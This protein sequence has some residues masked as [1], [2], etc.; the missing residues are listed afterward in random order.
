VNGNPL[1]P[2]AW[3]VAFSSVWLVATES[4]ARTAVTAGDHLNVSP[5]WLDDR[6]L[7]FVS[8][9]DGRREVYVVEIGATGPAGAA[10]KVPGGTDAHSISV[11]ADGR[12]LAV[13]KFIAR[14]NVWSFPVTDGRP[15]TARE[16]RPVTSGT[17]VVETHALSPDGQSVVY[18]SDFHADASLYLLRINGGVPIPLVT[19]P[20]PVFFPAWSPDGREIAF[21]GGPDNGLWVVPAEGGAATRLT[22][23]GEEIPIWSRD[24]LTLAFRSHLTGR[25][26]AGIITRDRIGGRWSPPRRVTNFGCAFQLW[27]RDGSGLICGRP[28]T[29]VLTLVS[30]SGAVIW[31]R[32]LAVDG[33]SELGPPVSSENGAVLYLRAVRGGQRG[34]W[35]WPIAGGSARLVLPFADSSLVVQSYSGTISAANDRLYLTVG[36]FESDIWVMNLDWR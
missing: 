23:T 1:W 33:L 14:Q 25:T 30:P 6:H 13:A 11:S 28:N 5:A 4:G 19:S 8:D 34:I 22:E 32:D 2:R 17:Q 24:G 12:R 3:N 15:L 31:R 7:L 20:R 16:G 21:S 10:V 26:E 27:A 9:Q 29:T 36:E 18:N 35:A